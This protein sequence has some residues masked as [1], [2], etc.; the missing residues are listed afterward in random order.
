MRTSG[1]RTPKQVDLAAQATAFT[2][3]PSPLPR[4]AGLATLPEP[5]AAL[6][7]RKADAELFRCIVV[8]LD[9]AAGKCSGRPALAIKGEVHEIGLGVGER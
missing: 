6:P 3:A 2:F 7:D 4:L 9:E 5:A 8:P 1:E